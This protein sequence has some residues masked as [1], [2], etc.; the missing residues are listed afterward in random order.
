[1]RLLLRF[2]AVVPV[3]AALGLALVLVN[4]QGLKRHKI[5]LPTSKSILTPSPGRLGTVNSFPA[6][7]ALSPD[8]R[9]AALLNNGYGIQETQGRQSIAVVDLKTSRLSDF[10][11][12]RLKLDAQQSYFSRAAIQL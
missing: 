2:S 10:P 11:D 1:M 6:T 8:G 9:Y 4:G 12:D 3:V 5:N 7:I